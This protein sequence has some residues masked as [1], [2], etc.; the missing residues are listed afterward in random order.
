MSSP[1][2]QSRILIV[3][4]DEN[5][6]RLM[7]RILQTAGYLQIKGITDARTVLEVRRAWNPDLILLDLHMPHIDGI[8]LLHTFHAQA[9]ATEFVPILVLTADVS[10]ET[11]KRALTAGAND[12]VTKPVDVDE[13]LL[14]VRNLLA[15]RLS[16]EGLKN[17]NIAL[18]H[19]LR[20]RLQFEA[21]QSENRRNRI[22][23][24]RAVIERRPT[25]VFQPIIELSS[26]R[27]VGVEALARF[28][29]GTSPDRCF[30]EATTLGLGAELELAAVKA[31]LQQL[32]EIPDE[33]FMAVNV[34]P[35]VALDPRLHDL[36]RKQAH[37]RL[38][39]EITE[40]QPVDSYADLTLVR[41]R[42]RSDGIRVAIDDAGAGYASLHHILKLAP[43]IIKLDIGLTREID[44][45]PVKRA[46]AV[47]LVQFARETDAV[48]IAE[49]IET[50]SELATLRDLAVPWG[51][52]FHIG[53]PGPITVRTA[54]ASRAS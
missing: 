54:D 31:A 26:N 43:D 11:L 7:V 25:M 3:D 20:Q 19:E 51:Q 16:H 40:H 45:D 28:V 30:A 39:V 46:L 21:R 14:R 38:V 48:V 15:I 27:V 1:A 5:N 35:T 9:S 6:V 29:D 8:A 36:L 32:D 34:S 44:R 37:G 42:F 24:M 4:D 22:D 10:R 53:K 49:G 41:T 47:S 50:A 2:M 18:A 23:H 52:G 12:Y 17:S 13:V 33:Q